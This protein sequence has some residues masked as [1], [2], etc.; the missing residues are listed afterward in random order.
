MSPRD[1]AKNSSRGRRRK[2]RS[3]SSLGCKTISTWEIWIPPVIGVL[4]GDYVRGMWLSLQHDEPN[5]YVFGTGESHTVRELADFAFARVGLNAE[6]HV[7]VNPELVRVEPS[8]R[9]CCNASRVQS[10]ARVVPRSQFQATRRNDGG[11]GSC[12]IESNRLR[13]RTWRGRIE[14]SDEPISKSCS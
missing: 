9:L 6:D 1:G 2:R 7:R 13:S 8:T 12:S 14:S 4:P 3:E 11:C 10:Q 5:D